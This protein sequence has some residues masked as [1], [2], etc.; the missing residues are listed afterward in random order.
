MA[1][2]VVVAAARTS[3]RPSRPPFGELAARGPADAPQNEGSARLNGSERRRDGSVVSDSTAADSRSAVSRGEPSDET[4]TSEPRDS[5]ASN[6]L[7]L[8]VRRRANGENGPNSDLVRRSRRD[9]ESNDS[10]VSNSPAESRTE[11]RP[12]IAFGLGSLPLTRTRPRSAS[13]ETSTK[14]ST[15]SGSRRREPRPLRRSS[16]ILR[17]GGAREDRGRSH[18]GSH[19]GSRRGSHR[20]IAGDCLLRQ[21]A[22]H[23]ER[24]VDG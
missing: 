20:E 13:G 6:R 15:S 8:P 22:V 12:L 7:A 1:A 17:C 18:R 4:D 16:A 2:V 21:R 19:R 14:P 23:L 5:R 9:F 10:P 24:E 11:P 3:R